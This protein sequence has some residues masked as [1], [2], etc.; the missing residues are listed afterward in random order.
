MAATTRDHFRAVAGDPLAAAYSR[1]DVFLDEIAT[2]N[3]GVYSSRL[4]VCG[5]ETGAALVAA[6]DAER[7]ETAAASLIRYTMKRRTYRGGVFSAGDYSV[8]DYQNCVERLAQALLRKRIAFADAMLVRLLDEVA[9]YAA[10]NVRSYPIKGLLTQ[11]E[12][13]AKRVG[14]SVAYRER[15]ELMLAALEAERLRYAPQPLP[16][17]CRETTRRVKALLDGIAAVPR[18]PT[19]PTSIVTPAS[20]KKPIKKPIKK[21]RAR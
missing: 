2:V 14:L 4:N 9:D 19:A 8:E 18:R 3:A 10:D 1:I 21:P 11:L 7:S 13:H 20:K 5:Y 15:L 17:I 12:H 6:P 16:Q